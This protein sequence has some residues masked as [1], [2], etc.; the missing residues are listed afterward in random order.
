[1]AS[2]EAYQFLC[3][4]CDE[5]LFSS[6]ENSWLRVSKNHITLNPQSQIEALPSLDISNDTLSGSKELEDCETRQL[7]CYHCHLRI[8]VKC[9]DA[10]LEKD[11]FMSVRI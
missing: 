8:G 1:M 5:P 2:F 9:V 4:K 10:S 7:Y 3:A 11:G 6:L